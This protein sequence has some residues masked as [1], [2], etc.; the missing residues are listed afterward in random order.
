MSLIAVPWAWQ[1]RL[2][3]VPKLV[4]LALAEVSDMS[5][6]ARPTQQRL[7]DLTSLAWHEVEPALGYLEKAGL[8]RREASPDCV[9]CFLAVPDEDTVMAAL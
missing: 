5:E 7:L 1:Q 3:A 6:R 4:L 8:L 9:L 2:P